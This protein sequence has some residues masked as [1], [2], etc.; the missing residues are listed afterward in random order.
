[1]I[2]LNGMKDFALLV[3]ITHHVCF[4]MWMW[5]HTGLFEFRKL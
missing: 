2:S 4:A 3:K 1:M 5:D